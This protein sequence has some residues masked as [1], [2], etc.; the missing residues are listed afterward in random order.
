MI[1]LG[2]AP[3]DKEGWALMTRTIGPT[4]IALALATFAVTMLVLVGTGTA[5][6]QQAPNDPADLKMRITHKPAPPE[7]GKKVTI[8]LA[9]TN[10]GPDPAANV[11]I[12]G[13]ITNGGHR[14]TGTGMTSSCSNGQTFDECSALLPAGATLKQTFFGI[15]REAQRV[16]G[17]AVATSDTPDPNNE[18]DWDA[19][20]FKV[21]RR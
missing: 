14:V 7:V 6:A 11:V 18:N 16:K 8:T 19:F 2:L 9:V 21:H 12:D 3:K 17:Y 4:A 15:P 1:P 5:S 10:D 20:S 13:H